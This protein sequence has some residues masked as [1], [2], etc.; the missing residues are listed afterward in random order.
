[1]IS[2]HVTKESK[3]SLFAEVDRKIEGMKELTTAYAR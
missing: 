1:M 2:I 3:K